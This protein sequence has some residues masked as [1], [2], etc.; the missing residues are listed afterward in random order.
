[1]YSHSFVKAEILLPELVARR[2]EALSIAARLIF[3][4]N[5]IFR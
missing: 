5:R 3:L 1:M 4:K 2:S